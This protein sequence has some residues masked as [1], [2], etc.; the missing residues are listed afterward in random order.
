MAIRDTLDRER[1]VNN[2][3]DQVVDLQKRVS[4]LEEQLQKATAAAEQPMVVSNKETGARYALFVE[5]LAE[6]WP[7]LL[8]GEL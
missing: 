8:M 4:R 2:L 6:G 3:I 7:A 1:Q 5:D